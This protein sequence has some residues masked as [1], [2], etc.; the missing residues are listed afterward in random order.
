ME[1][2]GFDLE[3][4]LFPLAA[5]LQPRLVVAEGVGEQARLGLGERTLPGE[6]EEFGKQIGRCGVKGRVRS[7]GSSR[8]RT[9]L[10]L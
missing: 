4:W 1:R 7:P 10:S 9:A 5:P 8:N 6:L 2:H 3:P